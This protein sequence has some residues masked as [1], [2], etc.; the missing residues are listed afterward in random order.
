MSLWLADEPLVLASKS[1]A[2]RA[3]LEAAG[4]A[5][6]DRARR[7]RR[8]RRSRARAGRDDPARSRRC[9]RARRRKAVAAQDARPHGA[10]RRPDAGARRAAVL[11]A[12]R[13]RRRARAACGAARQDACAAFGGRGGARRRGAVRACRRR[14]ADD[15]HVLGRLSRR[16]ISTRSGDAATASVGGYQLESAGIQLFE[17]VEGDHFTILGLPLLPLLDFL[18]RAGLLAE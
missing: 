6:R 13:S 7:H 9:W 15:A 3:L 1:A 10:R 16:A 5:G 17:R 12:G 18:R 2:R 8:A 4:I 11:Q 14:A